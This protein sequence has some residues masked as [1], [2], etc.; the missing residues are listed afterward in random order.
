MMRR[1]VADRGYFIVCDADSDADE[2]TDF[3]ADSS[4]IWSA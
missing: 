2:C 1:R 3:V 4:A